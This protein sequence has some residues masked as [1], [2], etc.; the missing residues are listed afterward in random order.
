[1]ADQPARQNFRPSAPRPIQVTAR[2]TFARRQSRT[3][4]ATDGTNPRH[5][6]NA[7]PHPPNV[8]GQTGCTDQSP[9]GEGVGQVSHNL[10]GQGTR[11]PNVTGRLHPSTTQIGRRGLKCSCG[12]GS[13]TAD[14][15]EMHQSVGANLPFR[16]ASR[17]QSPINSIK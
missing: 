7:P 10:P 14:C 2:A 8:H 16:E 11:A 12:A 5:L 17:N 13:I 3:R 6:H 15:P 1:M 4:P 9:Q